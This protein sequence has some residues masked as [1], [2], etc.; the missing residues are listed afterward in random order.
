MD[1][2]G[3]D[4]PLVV[5]PAISRV[6]ATILISVEGVSTK[7]PLIGKTFVKELPAKVMKVTEVI[8]PSELTKIIEVKDPLEQANP[9]LSLPSTATQVECS[10]LAPS[11]PSAV[12]NFKIAV[13]FLT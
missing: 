3:K 10:Q 8:K 13:E 11:S 5:G 9:N 12:E 1:A 6:E 7:E 2:G 4:P